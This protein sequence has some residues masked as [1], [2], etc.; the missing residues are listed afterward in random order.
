[1][2]LPVYERHE[3]IS[4]LS[5]PQVQPNPAVSD[6]GLAVSKNLEGVFTRIQEI[7]NGM[8]DARTLELF[9]KFK[10]DSQEYHEN[11]DKGIYNTRFGYQAYGIYKEA[12][13]WLRRKGEDYARELPSR[14][15]QA[16]FR[17]MAREHIEQRGVQNSKFE[18]AQMLKYQNEQSNAAIKNALAYAEQNWN[19]P[20]AINKARQDIRPALEL[21]TRGMGAEAF[22]NAY[23]DIEDQ[24]GVARIRQ[25]FVKD[26]LEAL[27]MLSNPDIHLKPD[28]RAKLT[29]SLT[30][31]TEVYELQA[32]ASEYAKYYTPTNAV[33]AQRVLIERY[34]AD[35]GQKAFAA[36]SRF[37]SIGDSQKAARDRAEREAMQNRQ[38]EYMRRFNDPN[39][40]LP[41]KE[42]LLNDQRSRRIDPQFVASALHLIDA[43]ENSERSAADKENKTQIEI[44]LWRK[45]NNND[46]MTDEELEQLVTSRTITSERA[47]KHKNA[48]DEYN[49]SKEQ[50]ENKRRQK[51]KSAL[52]DALMDGT[53]TETRINEARN[54]NDITPED[55]FTLSNHLRA[56]IERSE[57]N[58]DRTTRQAQEER[59]A[60][61]ERLIQDGH[62]I[63]SETANKWYK[64]GLIDDETRNMLYRNENKAKEDYERARVAGEKR[65]AK[66]A[67]EKAKLEAKKLE[68]QRKD[69]LD[70]EA[71]NLAD[72]EWG[73]EGEAS[74]YIHSRDDLSREE[75]DFLFQRFQIHYNDKKQI[76]QDTEN[77][78]KK[79]R[80]QNQEARRYDV[81]RDVST[82]EDVKRYRERYGAMYDEG[83]LDFKEYSEL[84]KMLDDRENMFNKVAE[85]RQKQENFDIAKRLAAQY[86]L[87][88]EH[89]A[90][91]EINETYS[92]PKQHDDI[93]KHFN[94]FI[95]DMR[96][97]QAAKDKAVKAQQDKT[98]EEIVENIRKTFTPYN[99]EEL[100][101]LYTSKGI[102][103]EQA[104]KIRQ[105]N[106]ALHRR[107]DLEKMLYDENF[108]GFRDMPPP[109]AGSYDF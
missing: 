65:R 79:L 48:R 89:D 77:F 6:N 36:L 105:L 104:E 16:N 11:P 19:N 95:Q 81:A 64:K 3:G 54:N 56:E 66:E 15:S 25:A 58:E 76:A 53:L 108:N 92:D 55:A 87:D 33:E 71:K 52:L 94:G 27:G 106:A 32:I 42:E 17:K 85:D 29:E 4:P 57:R 72:R 13:E 74:Q 35:K 40:P 2:R 83:T 7:Q 24:L 59:R 45:E 96:S 102:R 67:E 9:N 86:G 88:G 80:E 90:R 84:T 31:S 38:D 43:R 18:A 14:R 26:P 12:D 100:E 61:L 46:F 107:Q 20:E 51:N 47:N 1:M 50:E 30:K 41:T 99:S 62:V 49:R 39:L 34:G 5:I 44:N 22:K 109:P 69:E 97:E 21:K 37:W 70:K 68:E 78:Y 75:R 23:D 93:M 91:R 73:Y 103:Y 60:I 98:Y 8:E 28:T 101:K 63:S 82:M 10:M